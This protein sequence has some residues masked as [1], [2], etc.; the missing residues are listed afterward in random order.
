MFSRTSV[1]EGTSII[2]LPPIIARSV[3]KAR[4]RRR[5]RIQARNMP[6][7]PLAKSLGGDG[8]ALIEDHQGWHAAHRI[9][10]GDSRRP[11]HLHLGTTDDWLQY[12]GSG[13]KYW[14]HGL[15]GATPDSPEIHNHGQL[16]AC[17]VLIETAVV[18]DERPPLEQ[19][20]MT[21]AT[22]SVRRQAVHWHAVASATGRAD[23]VQMRWIHDGP[24]A[25]KHVVGGAVPLREPPQS[26]VDD[27]TTALMQV[28]CCGW[29]P[30]DQHHDSRRMHL[31]PR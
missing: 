12:L 28:R 22:T 13:V 26:V 21:G 30:D 7:H 27:P 5:L 17:D 24:Y 18:Q 6:L 15:A 25:A 20:L 2:A 14:S 4:S 19:E 1:E 29:P 11:I 10:C 16:F 31:S 9:A 3:S 23:G 8:L